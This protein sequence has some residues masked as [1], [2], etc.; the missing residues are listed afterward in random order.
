MT[1]EYPYLF[2]GGDY[3]DAGYDGVIET[4]MVLYVASP[5]RRAAARA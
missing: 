2:H 1:G 3:D 5:A 4:G